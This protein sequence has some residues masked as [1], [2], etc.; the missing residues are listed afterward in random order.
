MATSTMPRSLY[1]GLGSFSLGTAVILTVLLLIADPRGFTTVPFIGPSFAAIALGG[2]VLI[3]MSKDLA[4][5]S[6]KRAQTARDILQIIDADTI[7][8]EQ[9]LAVFGL[10]PGGILPQE[11]FAPP[12]IGAL[13]FAEAALK[14]AKLKSDS[15][16]SIL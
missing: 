14:R 6:S 10:V 7:T 15:S 13:G 2:V 8:T 11:M 16:V 3:V 4:E 9:K 12:R 5:R 1:I